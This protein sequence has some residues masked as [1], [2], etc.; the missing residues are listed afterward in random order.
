MIKI[1]KIKTGIPVG[2]DVPERQQFGN[3]GRWVHN[4]MKENGFDVVNGKGVDIPSIGVEIKSRKIESNSHHTV[5][6]M[7]IKEII[8]TP[9]DLSVVRDKFQKQYRVHYSDEGQIVTAEG[10]VDLTDD[11]IQDKIRE[12]YEAGR[13]KIIEN[14]ENGYHPPYVKGTEWGHFEITDSCGSYCFRIPNNAM[15]KIEKISKNANHFG[16]LFDE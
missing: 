7:N 16:N 12:A 14:K 2:T 4:K 13:K 6:T 9:Y 11:Y 5:G 10:L 15:K 8:Y 1:S 3:V